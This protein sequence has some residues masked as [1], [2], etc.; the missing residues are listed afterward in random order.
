MQENQLNAWLFATHSLLPLVL[1]HSLCP[2]T[3]ASQASF[4]LLI[5][6]QFWSRLNFGEKST[7]CWQWPP[8]VQIYTRVVILVFH[9]CFLEWSD[10]FLPTFE[11]G[12]L[13][14]PWTIYFKPDGYAILRP[15]FCIPAYAISNATLIFIIL[16][17]PCIFYFK[18]DALFPD[19]I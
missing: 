19:A 11:K 16:P 8:N 17:S 5:A 6:C 3:S 9:T 7:C 14:I 2:A 13:I 15:P 1:H 10:V 4:T 18:C 12:Q